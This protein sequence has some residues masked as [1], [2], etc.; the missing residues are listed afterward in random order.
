[1]ERPTRLDVCILAVT[2]LVAALTSVIVGWARADEAMLTL[3]AFAAAGFTA[4]YWWVSREHTTRTG[5]NLRWLMLVMSLI[6]VQG[7]VSDWTEQ[8]YPG[9]TL[10]RI[11]LYIAATVAFSR[12]ITDVI[13]HHRSAN[14]ER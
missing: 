12:L 8:D 11:C 10:V 5:R 14:N 6:F 4:L 3:T 7:S 13:D 2:V 1:M 9:R